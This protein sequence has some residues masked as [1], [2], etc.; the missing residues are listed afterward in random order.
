MCINQNMWSR[1]GC[2]Q[3]GHNCSQQLQAIN[4]SEVLINIARRFASSMVA[5]C[6]VTVAHLYNQASDSFQ[7]LKLHSVWLACTTAG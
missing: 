5:E 1:Q 6:C 3:D 4:A 7:K 2:M